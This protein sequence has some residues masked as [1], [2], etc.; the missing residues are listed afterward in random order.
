MHLKVSYGARRHISLLPGRSVLLLTVVIIIIFN[1]NFIITNTDS[2][3]YPTYF[4]LPLMT[5]YF[6]DAG[7]N[8]VYAGLKLAM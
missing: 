6:F 5:S 7:D 4:F 8:V 1:D 2:S 3:K